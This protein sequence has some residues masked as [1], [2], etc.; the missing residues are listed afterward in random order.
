MIIDKKA[1][2]RSSAKLKNRIFF[3]GFFALFW[4]IFSING[5]AFPWPSNESHQTDATQSQ[6][7]K[8][9]FQTTETQSQIDEMEFYKFQINT[10]AM[11][12]FT[13]DQIR[14][15]T[16]A[17]LRLQHPIFAIKA[18]YTYSFYENHHYFRPYQFNVNFKRPDG[19]WIIGRKPME[20]DWA[21]SFWN[22]GLW[23]PS[24][25]DDALRPQ[26]AGLTG[27]FRDFNFNGGKATLF[28]SFIFLPDF[29]PSFK[30][31]DGKI[32]SDNPWFTPPPS[33]KV[34]GTDTVLVYK[35]QELSFIDFLNLSL[36]INMEYEGFY[37]SYAY[38]PMNQIKG[39]GFL[40]FNLAKALK[41][42]SEDGYL[43]DFPVEM[44]MLQH[45]LLS[46]G[47]TL[48]SL[49]KKNNKQQN[50]NYRLQTSF[51]YNHPEKPTLEDNSWV[52]F[53]P[54]NEW[55]ISVKGEIHVK[56]PY[57]ETTL[58]AGY[59]HQFYPS[60]EKKNLLSK[61]F[62][63]IEKQFVR[64]DLFHFS[65]SASVGIN[66]KIQ[67]EETLALKI[68]VRLIYNFLKEYFL[69]SAHCAWTFEEAFSFFLS[70]DLLFSEFPFSTEQTKQDIGIY[71]N[72]SR[73]FGGF[74]YDF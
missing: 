49:N 32:T 31:E 33:G 2:I 5:L 20:W 16:S 35:M 9:Q 29:P 71:T 74:S 26:W 62:L 13:E 40:N 52:F 73:I 50:T 1:L 69:F 39:K 64:D 4:L 28:G 21:D 34:G 3:T 54:R 17:H 41:G 51:T 72:K 15:F 19:K 55:H 11:K 23:Q 60:E 38:K 63:G 68:N 42:T 8:T 53:Q 66:H 59:T 30:N 44:V 70:S 18:S 57:E 6:T 7:D 14:Y 43:L 36:G 56:D 27:L 61:V 45:H 37:F 58:H 67:F 65:Q 48:D 22:R 10:Q 25:T 24:Y 46:G 12:F 47:F